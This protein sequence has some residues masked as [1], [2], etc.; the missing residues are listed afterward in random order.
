MAPFQFSPA[1]GQ[2]SV[3]VVPTKPMAACRIDT[4]DCSLTIA[5][6][7]IGD[8]AN[9][10]GL[11]RFGLLVIRVMELSWESDGGI[12][13]KGGLISS[14][15]KSAPGW[16]NKLVPLVI[17]SWLTAN[18]DITGARGLAWKYDQHRLSG[19]GAQRTDF[20]HPDRHQR[21]RW[22]HFQ[23]A[24]RCQREKLSSNSNYLACHYPN[25]HPISKNSI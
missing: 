10:S 17:G 5:K 6:R 2:I 15:D 23:L 11:N 20:R 8:V 16:P 18:R 12:S 21:H 24:G 9:Y 13:A 7:T 4:S 19:R 1:K 25:L 22:H 3:F 14:E